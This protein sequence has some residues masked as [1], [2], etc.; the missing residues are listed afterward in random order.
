MASF[1]VKHFWA[2]NQLGLK[3]L[4]PVILPK[5]LANQRSY[6][7]AL[8]VPGNKAYKSFAY[9]LPE[10]DFDNRVADIEK[11]QREL[12]LRGSA[13]D[14][15]DLQKS[16][17]YY[18]YVHSNKETLEQK[19]AELTNRIKEIYQKKDLSAEDKNEIE[20]LITKI[21]LIKQDIKVVREA[22]WDLQ[23]TVIPEV[24][25]LP[26]EIDP[27]TPSDAAIVVKSI[28]E[29]RD[30]PEDK[31]QSHLDIGRHLG[32][33][34]YKN[35]IQCY[36]CNEAV[37][38]E[39]GASAVASRILNESG[40]TR[41]AGPDF[42]RSLV[43]EGAGM[44][45]ESPMETFILQNMD[46]IEKDYLINRLHLVGG[47]SLPALLAMYTKQ[48]IKLNSFPLKVFTT[49]RQYT[50]FPSSPASYGLFSV[51]QSSA[52]QALT[53]VPKKDNDN[54]KS[55]LENLVETASK[56]YDEL[57]CHYRIVLRS[58]KEL[59][60]AESM[61]VSFEMWS[62]HSNQYIEV[63]HVSACG[64]YFSKRLS[65]AYQTSKSH[66]GFPATITGTLLSVPRVLGC[67][68]EENPDK[69]VLPDKAAE[70]LH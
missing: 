66:V 29:K 14:A 51:C 68:L 43:V 18:Q 65:F 50:P 64:D 5:T 6:T 37:V 10:I 20:A 52:I 31:R 13:I 32:L 34:E 67:L 59:R 57:D 19:H 2:R 63:G 42:A 30:V 12:S 28:G 4:K 22:I 8:Y 54:H 35:P 48:A 70:F 60:T 45:H 9:L 47:A 24:L 46:D 55:E 58:A 7:S 15:K 17:E 27:H 61:R 23:E 21:R 44:D 25:K 49:G 36:L 41:V 62:A 38:F 69:F 26:N 53:L 1:A 40:A 11:L 56:I 33:L 16:W 3:V 39:L